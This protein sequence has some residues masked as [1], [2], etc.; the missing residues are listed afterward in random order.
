MKPYYEADGITLYHGDARQVLPAAPPKSV[1]VTDPPYGIDLDVE[2]SKQKSQR[3]G[4]RKVENDA[5]PFD[6]AWLLDRFPRAVIFGGNNFASQLPDSGAWIIWDKVLKNDLGVRI[7][8][9]ELAWTRGV[10]TRTRVFRHLWSGMFRNSEYGTSYH[11][12]QK[13]VTMM[14]WIIRLVSKPDDT[15]VDPYAGSGS[16]LIAA[17]AEGRPAVGCEI[18]ERYCEVTAQRL[19]QGVLFGGAA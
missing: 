18:D 16:T 19:A 3:Q 9:A 2:W 13:P 12:C 1:L 10:L 8:E 5:E 4:Q 14:G 15:I 6:P 7:A 17:K 11:P